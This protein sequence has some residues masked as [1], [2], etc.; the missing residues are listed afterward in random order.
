MTDKRHIGEHRHVNGQ[1]RLILLAHDGE[2][3][4]ENRRNVATPRYLN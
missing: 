2:L 4:P 3:E 1:E